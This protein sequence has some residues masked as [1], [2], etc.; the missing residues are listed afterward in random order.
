MG[1]WCGS[2]GEKK[3]EIEFKFLQNQEVVGMM[4]KIISTMGEYFSKADSYKISFQTKAIPEEKML[5]II[6]VYKLIIKILKE[7]EHHVKTLKKK[8]FKIYIFLN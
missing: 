3:T 6:T 7:M 8:V 4:K 1:F 2:S 5:L